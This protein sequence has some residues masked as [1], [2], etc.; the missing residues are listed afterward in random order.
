MLRGAVEAAHAAV[1]QASKD[2]PQLE[3]MGT[4]VVACMLHDDRVAVAHVGDSRLYRFRDGQLEQLTQ[5]H[6]ML[7]ELIAKGFYSREEALQQVRRNILTRAVGTGD[8]ITVDLLDE[9]LAV[10]EILLLCSDGLTDMLSD[11]EI[12]LTLLEFA[13]RL[14]EAADKLIAKANERGGKDNVSVVLASVDKPFAGG[15]RLLEKLASWF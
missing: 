4:T 6:T 8:L 13:D 1:K 12:R 10:G 2:Q 7:E 3:G 14:E 9:P 5:D 15:K 11:D